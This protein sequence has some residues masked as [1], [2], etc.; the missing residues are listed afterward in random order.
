MSVQVAVQ[1][2]QKGAEGRVLIQPSEGVYVALTA[3]QARELGRGIISAAI[4]LEHAQR[5][6]KRTEKHREAIRELKRSAAVDDELRERD[7]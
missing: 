2:P 1:R 4:D 6:Q 3:D 5:S 7:V